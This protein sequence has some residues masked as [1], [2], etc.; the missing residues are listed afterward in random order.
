MCRGVLVACSNCFQ[1]QGEYQE[2][3]Q[4]CDNNWMSSMGKRLFVAITFCGYF[5][6]HSCILILNGCVLVKK[7]IAFEQPLPCKF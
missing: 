1:S 5:W 3:I 6:L 2:L 7:P 4:V